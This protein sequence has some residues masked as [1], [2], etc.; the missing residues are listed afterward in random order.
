VI[1][2]DDIKPKP[3]A[4]THTDRGVAVMAALL[5][6]GKPAACAGDDRFIGDEY[7]ALRNRS[8]RKICDGCPLM[9]ACAEWGI[10]HEEYGFW[11]GLTPVERDVARKIRGQVRVEPHNGHALAPDV[12]ANPH[13]SVGGHGGHWVPFDESDDRLAGLTNPLDEVA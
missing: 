13:R 12:F 10:A 11:G 6:A 2:A 1:K 3:R 8:L 7:Y 4:F 5:P 9:D